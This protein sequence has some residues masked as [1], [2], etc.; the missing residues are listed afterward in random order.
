MN[1]KYTHENFRL[2]AFDHLYI[3][4]GQTGMIND[5]IIKKTLN[6]I[7]SSP[8][9]T[10]KIQKLYKKTVNI[11]KKS[12]QYIALVN[13]NNPFQYPR[14]IN[15]LV[16]IG[17]I[18]NP[19]LKQT[20][21]FGLNLNEINQNLLISGRAGSGK[22]TLLMMMLMQFIK[23]ELP[24]MVLDFKRD[25]RNLI[26][27][28]DNI[29]IYNW[30]LFRF[31]PLAPPPNVDPI[32]WTQIL[33]D[34]FFRSFFPSYSATASKLVFM[35]VLGSML[36]K[37]NQLSF[38][39]FNTELGKILSGKFSPKYKER[40]NTFRG[41][42]KPML[43]VLGDMFDCRT[44]FPMEELLNKNVVLEFDGVSSEIQTFLVTTIFYWIFT[45]R[46]NNTQ[47]GSLKHC[48]VFD[49]A[50]M[51]FS[52]EFASGS[53]PL[54][55]L[56]ST[57]REFGEG[58]ILSDQM[59]S[60]LGDAI[61]AN[62]Y[63]QISLS[64]SSMKDIRGVSSAMGLNPEQR[65]VLN[66]LPM[67]TG[68]CKM[69]GRYMNPFTFRLPDMRFDKSVTD[70][71][72]KIHMGSKAASFK[73]EPLKTTKTPE[74]HFKE[75]A[76]EKPDA[77][78]NDQTL[79]SEHAKITLSDIRNH[80][81]VPSV[82]RTKKLKFTTYMMS[83]VCRELIEKSLIK[84]VKVKP[85][86]S[87]RGRPFALYELTPKG[88]SI[89]GPQNLGKGKGGLEHC[90]YQHQLQTNFSQCGWHSIIEEYRNGKACDVGITGTRKVAI[91]IAASNPSK[92]LSNIEKNVAA[93]W[94]EIW[95]LATTGKIMEYIESD[96]ASHK[97]L[98][99][100]IK[101]KFCLISDFR[102]NSDGELINSNPLKGGN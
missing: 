62:V 99:P 66:S 25:Y 24:F 64:L 49:E 26:R 91:E 20:N 23:M 21:P 95:M 10:E 84:E 11:I 72:V 40:I 55:R 45:Y 42:I 80:P 17:Q 101:V 48:L 31:N 82:K 37:D 4:A 8:G 93:G 18:H 96:W 9:S 61:L 16:K 56:V 22:T 34:V 39:E 27:H 79:L 92:E 29:H 46:I 63:T 13:D 65:Q 47:R 2:K 51:V 52:K 76:A 73:V 5:P 100:N 74:V 19:I 86:F 12:P 77:P 60:S 98:Y 53:S 58:L 30:K 14:D 33:S 85:I 88:K 35:D 75:K 87:G 38:P 3:L 59:P 69:A 97:K 94:K 89:T 50:K 90:Y 32:Y 71:E 102:I 6:I 15:G 54:S 43:Q 44:G 28:T 70:E 83:K 68:V 41:R 78:T 7:A 81:Y 57:A 67:R 36:S 1:N